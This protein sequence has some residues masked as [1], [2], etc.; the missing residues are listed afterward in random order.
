MNEL[1]IYFL[2]N[3]QPMELQQ[4]YQYNPPLHVAY[5]DALKN[6]HSA[7]VCNTFSCVLK[8]LKSKQEYFTGI[9]IPD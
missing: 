4:I 7:P 9:R 6:I 5:V 8:V 3:N 1:L 2:E